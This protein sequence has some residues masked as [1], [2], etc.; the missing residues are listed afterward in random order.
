[1]AVE[2]PRELNRSLGTAVLVVGLLSLAAL[3]LWLR[4]PALA[5]KA[6]HNDEAV[7]G[8]FTL[9][10]YWW[11]RYHYNPQ[12]YHGPF[13]YYV[14]L[15][16]FWLFGPSEFS[17]RLGTVVTGT[18]LPIALLPARRFVGVFG[19]LAAG[20]L[21]TV[22]PGFVYFSR[23]NIHE[24]HL[25]LA[26]ALWA[27]GLARFAATPS[28]PWAVVS[29]LGG[30]L[31]FANKETALIT[32][33]TLGV[34]AGLAWLAGRARAGDDRNDD[35]D[36]FGGRTRREAL[37]AWTKEARRPW[38][39]GAVAFAVF[40]VVMFTTFF[41]WL[42]GI[43]A[44]FQAFVAWFDHGVTGRNQT[45]AWDYFVR[46]GEVTTLTAVVP[47]ALAALWASVR[48]HRLGLALVGWA[49]SA[50]AVYSAVP[51]KTPWCA[52]NIELP[53]FLL[54]GWGVGQAILQGLDPGNHP[55][56]RALAFLLLPTV[57]LPVPEMIEQ[58]VDVGQRRYDD[59]TV[60]YVFVQTKREV[61]DLVSDAIG[62]AA[63]LD[64]ADGKGPRVLNVESKN[65]FR[66]Y[67]LTRGWDHART[68]YLYDPPTAEQVAEADLVVATGK[69]VKDVAAA[70]G[71]S[72]HEWHRERYPLRPGH[73]ITAWFR[74][75]G[76]VAYQS[77]GGRSK[78]PWP[79]PPL[80][81]LPLPSVKD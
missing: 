55:A 42:P 80:N 73:E 64:G 19:I 61:L 22:A 72:P 74:L 18:L 35:P 34:G 49:L 40:T 46:V 30:A 41:S 63:A 69:Q 2:G 10:L 6:L 11:N 56:A 21:L 33:G 79:I 77:A 59:G 27:A 81:P 8:W 9:R 37:D 65:P 25:I 17:L 32:M 28:V 76:W 51:Y 1:M 20:L 3:S 54:V 38:A 7:N 70:I 66:W 24:I 43:G 50:F 53:L 67:T 45:K 23:T 62:Y 26:T 29:G 57:A 5:D 15:V 16:A 47:A 4:L 58:S 52:L 78:V 13:L 44:F 36:L 12:D 75:D 60:P 14:N 71:A 31:A 68:K 39:M 48:R